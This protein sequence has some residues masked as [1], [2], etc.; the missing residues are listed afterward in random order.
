MKNPRLVSFENNLITLSD[1]KKKYD[2]PVCFYSEFPSYIRVF[3]NLNSIVDYIYKFVMELS[4]QNLY[5]YV[6]RHEITITKSIFFVFEI[7]IYCYSSFISEHSALYRIKISVF[8]F[9]L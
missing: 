5:I 3:T 4:I 1:F 6:R 7:T 2:N 9:E 8:V